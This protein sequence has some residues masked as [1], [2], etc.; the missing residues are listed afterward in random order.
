MTSP[1]RRQ[2]RRDYKRYSA[3]TWNEQKETIR[4]LVEQGKTYEEIKAVLKEHHDFE[5]GYD[6]FKHPA[7]PKE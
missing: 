5:I 6:T 3:Q 2:S 4:A 1:S 7:S